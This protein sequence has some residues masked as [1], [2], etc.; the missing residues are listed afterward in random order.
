[1]IKII[2]MY[3]IELIHIKNINIKNNGIYHTT[4]GIIIIIITYILNL[5][6]LNMNINLFLRIMIN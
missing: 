6:Y 3:N 1:M 4:K 5:Y 2:M